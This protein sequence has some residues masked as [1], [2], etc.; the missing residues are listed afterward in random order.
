M[1]NFDESA[2][3]F[4]RRGMI[5]PDDLKRRRDP[6]PSTLGPFVILRPLGQ[7][8]LGDVYLATDTRTG[9]EVAL[10]ILN[11]L[12]LTRLDRFIREAKLA[13]LLAY[14]NIVQVY[15][16][17]EIEGWHYISMQYIDG[18]PI[19]EL[20]MTPREAAEK[21]RIV[22][23]AAHHAHRNEIIHRDITPKNVIVHRSTGMPYLVDFGLAKQVEG[24]AMS[25]TGAVLGT[26]AYMSPE[27]ARGEV[28]R[29]DARTDVYGLGATLYALVVGRAPFPEESLYAT[30]R[31][32]IEE[33]PAM[34]SIP[35]ALR[36]ILQKAMSKDRDQRYPSAEALALDLQRFLEGKRVSARGP[37]TV[38]RLRKVIA[39]HR[40]A[41]VVGLIGVA[42]LSFVLAQRPVEQPISM[43]PAAPAVQTPL[44]PPSNA[45][46]SPA[47]C[48]WKKEQPDWS[49]DGMQIRP[50]PHEHSRDTGPA[51]SP[52]GSLPE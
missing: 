16:A 18:F 23:L 13:S 4:L 44:L 50:P 48:S 36:L 43:P 12:A 8:G 17:G 20:R 29:L 14:P 11:R 37:S 38:Y 41:I 21:I 25:V 45:P 19:T 31:R 33:E 26:P 49:V 6:V 1:S 7:G 9:R 10:K 35:K 27:Q 28:N 42:A 3:E 51:P 22:A 47:P 15:E 34:P 46:S 2:F 40:A 5:S 52:C 39:A 24:D 32:V 30:I